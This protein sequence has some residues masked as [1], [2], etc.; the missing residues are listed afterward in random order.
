[1][2]GAL[3]NRFSGCGPHNSAVPRH[4]FSVQRLNATKALWF[5][6]ANLLAPRVVVSFTIAAMITA[7]LTSCSHGSSGVHHSSGDGAA[8]SCGYIYTVSDPT[9]TERLGACSGVLY[10]SRAPTVRL[11]TGELLRMTAIKNA[12][13]TPVAAV[14]GVAATSVVRVAGRGR[15]T[16]LLRASGD[17]AVT[18]VAHSSF[19]VNTHGQAAGSC[20]VLHIDVV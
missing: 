15:A 11:T 18:L 5:R 7:S 14:P 16:I 19:C 13:G 4:D 9:G 20:P 17:G 1:V 12:D 2:E 8:S 3:V 6:L 10:A